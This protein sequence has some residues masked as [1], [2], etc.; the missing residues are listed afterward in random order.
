MDLDRLEANIVRMAGRAASAGVALRPH[1]KTH[2]SVRVAALQMDA[3]AAGLTVATLGEAET[4]ADGGCDDLF[5][6]YPLWAGSGRAQRLRALHERVRL[7]VGVD[8]VGGAAT[9]AAAVSGAQAPLEVLIEV[10]SGGE[11]TGVTI[12][13]ISGLTERCLH[14]GLNVVGAFTHPGHAYA[15][16]ARVVAAAEDEQST[17]RRAGETLEPLLDVPPVLSGG[18]TPTANA[19][20]Q[21]AMTEMRPGTYVFGDRQQMALSAL[22]EDDVALVIASRVVSTPRRGTAVLDAG[23]KTLSSDRPSWL[24]GFGL[25][26]G[27]P[28]GCIS[29]ISEEHAVVTGLDAEIRVGDLVAVVPNHVCTAVN[30]CAGLV[31]VRGDRFVDIWPVDALSN[32]RELLDHAD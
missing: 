2:K 16:R 19:D 15:G 20:V 22:P 18:S 32:R 3:G 31:T 13:E 7:R 26:P 5:V 9:L 4:F 17:L 12:D 24:P 28:E 1:A 21:V 30:L 29:S 10:D 6:A 23:S 25:L 8:N 11:R 27:A 14:L